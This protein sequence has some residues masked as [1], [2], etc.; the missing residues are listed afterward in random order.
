[1]P[2]PIEVLK[3]LKCCFFND[4]HIAI[5]PISVICGSTG[6]KDCIM[7]SKT[8]ELDCYNCKSKRKTKE[9]QNEQVIK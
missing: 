7:S 8:E 1:M 9:L 6:C 3:E 5:E 2:I 4:G